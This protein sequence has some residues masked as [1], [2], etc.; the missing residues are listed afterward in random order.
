MSK[1]LFHIF[2]VTISL[3]ATQTVSSEAAEAEPSEVA[4][5]Q[6]SFKRFALSGAVLGKGAG[7]G[8]ELETAMNP[9]LRA[10]I[11]VS[12]SMP[13][14]YS[15]P[16]HIAW[17]PWGTQPLSVYLEGGASIVQ[18][19]ECCGGPDVGGSAAE[20]LLIPT[21]GL[22]LTYQGESLIVKA[23]ADVLYTISGEETGLVT[24]PSVRIGFRF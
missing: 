19:R 23:G 20:T 17:V 18:T 24:L 8:V 2:I 22:G 12:T 3:C 9:Y 10:S 14:S 5:T 7:L 15:V 16:F 4:T 13:F 6:D 1:K 11:G 21:T